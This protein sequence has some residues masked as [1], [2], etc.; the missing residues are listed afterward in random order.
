[1]FNRGLAFQNFYAKQRNSIYDE[2]ITIVIYDNAYF[3]KAMDLFLSF[4]P[5]QNPV[6]DVNVYRCQFDSCCRN[7][8]RNSDTR[9]DPAVTRIYHASCMARDGRNPWW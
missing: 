4:A 2:D 3:Y 8:G 7:I 1:M 6:F 5:C 9:N